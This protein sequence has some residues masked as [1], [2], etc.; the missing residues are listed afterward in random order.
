MPNMR[1][2]LNNTRGHEANPKCNGCSHREQYIHKMS[3]KRGTNTMFSR[4]KKMDKKM[5]SFLNVVREG[6]CR[7]CISVHQERGRERANEEMIRKCEHKDFP[8]MLK[9]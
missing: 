7:A 8:C 3:G 1:I 2:A 6:K 4:F 9:M 5:K